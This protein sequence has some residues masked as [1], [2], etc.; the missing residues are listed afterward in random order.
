MNRNVSCRL[1][2]RGEKF[3]EK[4]YPKKQIRSFENFIR[5][6][7]RIHWIMDNLPA[8]TKVS[9]EG[10]DRYV[11]GYPIGF[12]DSAKVGGGRVAVS[13]NLGRSPHL[14]GVAA[15]F[16]PAPLFR[17]NRWFHMSAN[18]P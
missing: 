1:L 10:I 5:A 8:A 9:Y 7:Y 18:L 2:C 15:H 4:S 11:R 16:R 13:T 17:G 14:H 3:I 6:E 12:V